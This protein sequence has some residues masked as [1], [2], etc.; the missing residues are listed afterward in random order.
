MTGGFYII[1]HVTTTNYCDQA[2]RII[3]VGV[4]CLHGMA[5]TAFLPFSYSLVLFF[6]I[7]RAQQAWVVLFYRIDDF[8]VWKLYAIASC[9]RMWYSL[10]DVVAK[11]E[12]TQPRLRTC[13][14]S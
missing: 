2:K 7:A 11:Y 8:F 12:A 1:K 4:G 9:R 10:C 6:T 13:G 5:L 14:A 3:A